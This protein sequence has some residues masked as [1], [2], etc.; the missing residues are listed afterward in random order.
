MY[1]A[2][3]VMM[4]FWLYT[5]SSYYVDPTKVSVPFNEIFKTLLAFVIPCVIGIV[6]RKKKPRAADACVQV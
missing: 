6:L 3:S 4:P 2:V 1:C 5:L